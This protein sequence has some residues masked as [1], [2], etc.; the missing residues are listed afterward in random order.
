MTK[1]IL[2]ELEKKIALF[3]AKTRYVSNRSNGV[4]DFLY[5]K[6]LSKL[7]PDIMG[8]ESEIAAC[9]LLN[10]YPADLFT[11]GTKGV[12]SGLEMG[13]IKYNGFHIDVKATK[14]QSGCLVSNHKNKNIDVFML[15][16][17]SD[18]KYECRG[19]IQADILYKD[20]NFGNN[21]GRFRHPCWY[22]NQ[23]Q[24]EDYKKVLDLAA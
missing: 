3:V 20:S 11:L 24:L 7:E 5:A 16:V 21:D 14:W 15:M 13:D 4:N 8:A 23:P 17:G 6:N 10:A 1:V 18:G 12:K 22:L 19:A 2:N 9:K